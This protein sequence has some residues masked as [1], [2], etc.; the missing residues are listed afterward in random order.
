M[1]KIKPAVTIASNDVSGLVKQSV[2][3]I[4]K[5]ESGAG[6]FLSNGF[7]PIALGAVVVGAL[8]L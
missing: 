7:K 8:I 1:N 5:L 3:G 4:T 2:S 6:D